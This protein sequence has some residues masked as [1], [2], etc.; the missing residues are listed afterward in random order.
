M[1]K[2]KLVNAIVDIGGKGNSIGPSVIKD[3][4]VGIYA[5]DT[6]ATYSGITFKNVD[7]PFDLARG[8]FDIEGTRISSDRPK[9]E[10]K[11][12]SSYRHHPATG[13]AMP[14]QCESCEAIF[15][16]RNYKVMQGRFYSRDNKETC[17]MCGNF[18]AKVADGLYDITVEAIKVISGSRLAFEGVEALKNIVS[19]AADK[20]P[21]DLGKDIAS[22]PIPKEVKSILLR[23][24]KLGR[25]GFAYVCA[26]ISALLFLSNAINSF[27]DSVDKVADPSELLQNMKQAEKN[28]IDTF[29]SIMVE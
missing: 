10:N 22:S 28:V 8:A 18:N 4:K 9:S 29:T 6:D 3:A 13:P 15:P 11:A 26:A 14:A 27:S 20:S 16:S 17:P 21:E 2:P 23:A 12:R 19:S 25:K 7:Q 5:R 1:T 24:Q